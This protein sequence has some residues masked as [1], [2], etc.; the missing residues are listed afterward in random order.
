MTNGVIVYAW[1]IIRPPLE[2][3]LDSEKLHCANVKLFTFIELYRM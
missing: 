3:V 1:G 2:S